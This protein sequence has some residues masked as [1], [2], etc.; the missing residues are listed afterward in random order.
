MEIASTAS[1]PTPSHM[2]MDSTIAVPPRRFPTDSINRVMTVTWDAFIIL[3]HRVTENFTP[4]A[5]A[6]VT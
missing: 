6:P 3:F 5:R 2:K 1:F 4:R